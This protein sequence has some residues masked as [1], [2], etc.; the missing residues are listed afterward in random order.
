[1]TEKRVRARRP[2]QMRDDKSEVAMVVFL[3]RGVEIPDHFEIVWDEPERKPHTC[4]GLGGGCI[5]YLSYDWVQWHSID[6]ETG[7]D[8]S[9]IVARNVK[10]CPCCDWTPEPAEWV[11][12]EDVASLAIFEGQNGYRYIK[13][14][15]Q[16]ALSLMSG[17]VIWLDSDTL[18]KV[19]QP[20]QDAAK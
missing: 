11:R 2:G 7:V 14:N 1:M 17:E 10:R 13:L 8:G 5:T 20:P 9:W 3:R 15:W 12:F 16:D 19:I 6:R 18:F 4:E